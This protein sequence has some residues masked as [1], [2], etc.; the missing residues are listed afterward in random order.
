MTANYSLEYSDY[1]LD[2]GRIE[3]IK[4]AMSAGLA[5]A[6]TK[7]GAA[8]DK[9]DRIAHDPRTIAL[10]YGDTNEIRR[11]LPQK[12]I[13]KLVGKGAAEGVDYIKR[14]GSSPMYTASLPPGSTILRFLG[15]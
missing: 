1:L 8:K 9:I 6:K 11:L 15:T 13:G 10:S 5:V 2:E 3:N 12:G 4:K 7:A 14:V